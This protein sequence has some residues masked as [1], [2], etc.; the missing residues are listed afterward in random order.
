MDTELKAIDTKIASIRKRVGTLR[1][2]IAACAVLIMA[3]AKEH[4]D[5]S[6]ALRLVEVVPMASERVRLINWFKAFSPINVSWN[7]EASK[8]RVGYNKPD[9][10]AYNDFNLDG[11]KANPYYD[12]GKSDDDETADMLDSA[13]AN[14]FILRLADKMQKRIDKGEVAANDKD[15]VIAKIAALRQAATAVA[16]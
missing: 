10:K 4:G 3:H 8:R 1:T 7:A 5:C 15:N 2:D 11:A 6:R 14:T 13:G 16:A 12:F 9:A